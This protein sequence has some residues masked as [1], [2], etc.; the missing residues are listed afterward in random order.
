MKK[1]FSGRLARL[2]AEASAFINAYDGDKAI[3][4]PAGEKAIVLRD[5]SY[6]VIGAVFGEPLVRSWNEQERRNEFAAE[7]REFPESDS[8]DALVSDAW[9]FDE[10]CSFADSLDV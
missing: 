4:L 1:D 7:G 9:D 5:G 2:V 10:I 3:S 6:L 8:E